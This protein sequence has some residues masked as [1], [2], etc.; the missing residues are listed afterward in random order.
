[1]ASCEYWVSCVPSASALA[2]VISDIVT[3]RR[4]VDRISRSRNDRQQEVR[5]MLG[6]MID[7][8]QDGL[9]AADVVGNV[10]H[11]RG[12]A[13]AG[14]DVEARNFNADTVAP[15]ELIRGGHELD[16]VFVDLAGDDRFASRARER[17][18]R[19]AGQRSCRVD[20]AA[21]RLEPAARELAFGQ[22]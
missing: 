2:I 22:L 17:M 5:G 20:P 1:R 4:V 21:G 11:I 19:P 18:P 16:S 10:F 8:V 9:A 3:P 14:C 15:F 13:D 7:L 6:I 12:A